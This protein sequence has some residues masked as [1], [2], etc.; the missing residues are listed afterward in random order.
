MGLGC[1]RCGEGTGAVEFSD[2]L[3]T[4]RLG[5]L[6]PLALSPR[7]SAHTINS[8]YGFSH[9]CS[10]TWGGHNMGVPGR[11]T[12]THRC[13]GLSLN[14]VSISWSEIAQWGPQGGGPNSSC[15]SHLLFELEIL[16]AFCLLSCRF[17]LNSFHVFQRLNRLGGLEEP[18]S[19]LEKGDSVDGEES[20]VE[21]SLGTL[22]FKSF[23]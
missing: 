16:P 11:C 9:T 15:E 17:H 7:P 23:V 10:T 19:S 14:S 20:G 4:A 6:D 22:P 18:V 21:T 12:H 3:S 1:P 8:P 2:L 5:W 13:A